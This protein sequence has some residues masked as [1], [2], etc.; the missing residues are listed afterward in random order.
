[1]LVG[2]LLSLASQVIPF[3]ASDTSLIRHIP[4]I[5]YIVSILVFGAVISFTIHSMQKS[6]AN[7]KTISVM[8]FFGSIFYSI[9]QM[10]SDLV[11]VIVV[12]TVA[13]AF[14]AVYV[15]GFIMVTERLQAS[16]GPDTVNKWA[17]FRKG[18][19][20]LSSVM[21]LST[22]LLYVLD[23]Y[24]MIVLIAAKLIEVIFAIRFIRLLRKNNNAK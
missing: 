11:P 4:N 15:V 20:I 21:A 17:K 24:A 2:I 16:A 8:C 13:I 19:V 22:M 6:N 7:F 18:F 10:T 1:M 23:L 5:L 12:S 14:T 3:A 9:R